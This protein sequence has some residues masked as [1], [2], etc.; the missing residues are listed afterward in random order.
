MLLNSLKNASLSLWPAAHCDVSLPPRPDHSAD[1]GFGRERLQPHTDPWPEVF[2]K[3]PLCLDPSRTKLLSSC[4]SARPASPVT[5]DPSPNTV[6]S[7]MQ[8]YPAVLKLSNGLSH[9]LPCHSK[10]SLASPNAAPL[11]SLTGR[12]YP[13]SQSSL[14][15]LHLRPPRLLSRFPLSKM[16]YPRVYCCSASLIKVCSF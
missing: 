11:P 14:S 2:P 3:H 15:S 8:L 4:F 5:P 9:T 6:Y 10:P 16:P 1:I 13:I 12:T 7:T